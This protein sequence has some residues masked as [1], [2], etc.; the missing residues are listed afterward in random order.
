MTITLNTRNI[1]TNNDWWNQIFTLLAQKCSRFR[2][3][4]WNDEIEE[5]S[6]M[7]RF[8]HVS[9]TAW[10]HGVI[11]EGQVSASFIDSITSVCFATQRNGYNIMT[12]FFIIELDDIFSS[13]HYGT[14]VFI[15]H[16]DTNTMQD[17][18]SI[19]LNLKTTIEVSKG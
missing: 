1:K 4:C 16:L 18:D 5:I 17:I 12:P 13:A 6:Q 3:H 15:K 19:L 8:G 9:T 2:V 14:E 11:I 10:K 7:K